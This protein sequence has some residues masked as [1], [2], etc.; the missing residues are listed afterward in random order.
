MSLLDLENINGMDFFPP[1]KTDGKVMAPMTTNIELHHGLQALKSSGINVNNIPHFDWR[2]ESRQRGL[3]LDKVGNQ[4]ACGVCWAFS[5]TSVLTDRYIISKK[6]SGLHLDP[7]IIIA[8][9]KVDKA[10][11]GGS[12]AGAINFLQVWGTGQTGSK[13]LSWTNFCNQQSCLKNAPTIVSCN[14]MKYCD[15]N[16]KAKSNSLKFCIVGGKSRREQVNNTVANVKTELM[17]NG[18]VIGTYL[19]YAD[20]MASTGIGKYAS[21]G[22]LQKVTGGI[23]IHGAYDKWLS[24]NTDTSK[25]ITKLEKEGHAWQGSFS[26]TALG[27]HAVEIVGWGTD[28]V[29]N[30]GN[31][32]YW[33]VKNSW[34]D[35]WNGDGYFKYAMTCDNKTGK[36]AIPNISNDMFNNS[37]GL[38]EG[39]LN[40]T[41]LQYGAY[42]MLPDLDYGDA[43]GTTFQSPA[44]F[45]EDKSSNIQ[46]LLCFIGLVLCILIFRGIYYRKK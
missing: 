1:N 20:F 8:C 44:G 28:Y 45:D 41:G 32:Q 26:T 15:Q 46:G 19:V 29:P 22:A 24:E 16:Y 31:V 36:N 34:G 39:V 4:G 2:I 5:S 12:P 40:T 14:S 18:P 3:L 43:Y 10:C 27:G 25:F 33:I 7:L 37:C 17:L 38:A 30:I 9:D 11:M 6:L 13:C 42:S 21:E 35:K 23:Y